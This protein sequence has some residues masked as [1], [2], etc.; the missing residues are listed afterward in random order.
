LRE[1]A[2]V[3]V[4]AKGTWD[5]DIVTASSDRVGF[6]KLDGAHDRFADV[7]QLT[8]PPHLFGRPTSPDTRS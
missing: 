5:D 3:S 1:R 7:Q 8:V 2:N 4:V 6:G